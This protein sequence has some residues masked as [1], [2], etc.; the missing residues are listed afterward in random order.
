MKAAKSLWMLAAI[1]ICGTTTFTSCTNE[2]YLR[3]N[4]IHFMYERG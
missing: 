3:H 4:N 1:L 2:D